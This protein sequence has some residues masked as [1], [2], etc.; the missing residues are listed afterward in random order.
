MPGNRPAMTLEE[1]IAVRD[2]AYA[3]YNAALVRTTICGG[4]AEEDMAWSRYVASVVA[5]KKRQQE[6]AI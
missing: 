3:V 5:V 6:E 4:M 1:L 2:A